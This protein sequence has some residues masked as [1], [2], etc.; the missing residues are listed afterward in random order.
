MSILQELFG[1]KTKERKKGETILITTQESKI[2]TLLLKKN[3]V[4]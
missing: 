3:C 2:D 4:P 1:K